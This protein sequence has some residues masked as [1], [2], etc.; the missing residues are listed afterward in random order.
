MAIGARGGDHCS[1]QHQREIVGKLRRLQAEGRIRRRQSDRL[2]SRHRLRRG[3]RRLAG[4]IVFIGEIT[5]TSHGG[6]AADRRDIAGDLAAGFGAEDRG[7]DAGGFQGIV[8]SDITELACP[9]LHASRKTWNLRP[10][11]LVEKLLCIEHSYL[12]AV[13]ISPRDRNGRAENN[14]SARPIT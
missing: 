6:D 3:L 14:F 7:N 8:L 13:V 4:L 11:E 5:E 12:L 1:H 9:I 2:G 10:E